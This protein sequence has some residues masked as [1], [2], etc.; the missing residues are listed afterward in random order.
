MIAPL[1]PDISG[2]M[3]TFFIPGSALSAEF[4]SPYDIRE[5]RCQTCVCH[6]NM[7]K[8]YYAQEMSETVQASVVP[9]DGES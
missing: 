1:F 6:V 3:I 7:L 8:C 4:S 2:S 5:M 9:N